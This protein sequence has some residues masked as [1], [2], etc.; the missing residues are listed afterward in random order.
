MAQVKW[1][2]PD[3]IAGLVDYGDRSLVRE[4]LPF[5]MGSLDG[6][7]KEPLIELA[8]DRRNQQ[9]WAKPADYVLA[10]VFRRTSRFI[11]RI[12]ASAT[13]RSNADNRLK[14][15]HNRELAMVSHSRRHSSSAAALTR[16]RSHALQPRPREAFF[17]RE[18]RPAPVPPFASPH[19]KPPTG[20]QP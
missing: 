3:D 18:P 7:R 14:S 6:A 10:S 4:K 20:N 12:R 19:G 8:V 17:R 13:S 5:V 2:T 16:R 9:L 15:S 11:G 1:A